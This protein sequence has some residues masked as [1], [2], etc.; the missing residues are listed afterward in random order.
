MIALRDDI[1]G[2]HDNTCIKVYD[3]TI[4]KLIGV[5]PSYAAAG[6]KLGVSS[7]AVQQRCIRKTRVHSPMYGKEVACRI[8]KKTLEEETLM[9]SSKFKFL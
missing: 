2:L 3:P 6:K 5:Y 4:K 9:T 8:S 1:N 7:S